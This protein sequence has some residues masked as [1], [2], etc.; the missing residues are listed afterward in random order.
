VSTAFRYLIQAREKLYSTGIFRTRKLDHP[1][2]SVGNLT[3]GGTGKTPLVIALA[4]KFRDLGFHPVILS[5]GYKRKGRGIVVVG[6]SW[7]EAGDEP[8]L[9]ARRLKNVPVVVGADRY[10]AGRAAEQ[11]N[12]GD[13]FLLDDGFQHRQLHRDVDI[14][15][16]DL[17]EWS[18]GEALLPTGKWREPKS[19]I[20]RADLMCY[21]DSA[22]LAPPDLTVPSFRFETRIDGLYIKDAAVAAQTLQ[23]KEVVAFAAIAK[24]ERFFNA[25]ETIGIQPREKVTF[26]DH[27]AFSRTDIERLGGDVIITTEKDGVRLQHLAVRDFMELRISANIPDFAGLMEIVMGKLNK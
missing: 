4:E 15:A 14:V 22:N 19:A 5:R 2:V 20:L 27:H 26:R 9:M 1:V 6:D 13:I 12:L 18:A 11:R 3:L 25:L 16:I 7:E 21:Q 23:G 24:P 10:E 17:V 8:Y